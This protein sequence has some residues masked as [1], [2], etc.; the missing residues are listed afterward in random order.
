MN[1][2][3]LI[4]NTLSDAFKPDDFHGDFH[5]HLL[6]K[7][8]RM[9]CALNGKPQIVQT[10]DLLIWQM[11]TDFDD[12]TYSDDFDA[13]DEFNVAQSL[14]KFFGTGFAGVNNESFHFLLF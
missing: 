2:P 3:Y 10:G 5:V 12:I 11:T 6:C 4:Y 8:G 13:E 14:L 7:G 9:D 1:Q